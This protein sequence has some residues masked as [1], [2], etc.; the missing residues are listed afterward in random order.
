MGG[1]MAATAARAAA[2]PVDL[3][4]SNARP[5]KATRLKSD[6]TEDTSVEMASCLSG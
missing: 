1:S 6:V 4:L 5:R 3:T 2:E